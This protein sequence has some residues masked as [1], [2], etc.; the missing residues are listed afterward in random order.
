MCEDY[1]D[2]IEQCPASVSDI[3]SDSLEILLE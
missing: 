3:F 1:L 2:Q